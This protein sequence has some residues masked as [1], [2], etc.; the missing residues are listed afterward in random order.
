MTQRTL[1]I[2]TRASPLARW[3][4][5]WVA[6]RLRELDVPTE[7]VLVST[8]G[9]RE[10]SGPIGDLGGTGLFTKELQRALLDGEVDVAVHSLKDLP[11][12]EVE[13]LKLAAV[14]PRG[15]VGDVLLAAGRAWDDLPEGARIGTGSLRRRAHLWHA[16]PD[17]VMVDIR[18]NVDTRVRKVGQGEYDAIV[19]AEAGL[20]RLAIQVEGCQL[21]SKSLILPAVGQ[22]ALG[23]EARV[24]DR[25]TLERLGPLDDAATH[26]AVVAERAVLATL[27]GGCLAPIGAWGRATSD[28]ELTLQASV[29]SNR[30]EQKLEASMTGDLDD[31]LAL[32][33]IV[34]HDLLA[35][36]AERL[37]AASR[38][39]P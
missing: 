25:H 38:R 5:E 6:D 20:A 36:G 4:A 27:R 17:L 34:A 33:Q 39:A 13:G 9:D 3:Q 12:D 10:R 21:L 15:P 11:T 1:R 2:G 22:G 24:D 37:V 35:R 29:L 23:I 7:L 18:G 16:R 32:G 30:G 8:R 14:P 26:A 28:H 31:A 19:L